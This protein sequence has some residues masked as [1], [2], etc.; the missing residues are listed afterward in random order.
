MPL[1]TWLRNL[2][3]RTKF[4]LQLA[5]QV[6][7]LLLMGAM[8]FWAL[9][10]FEAELAKASGHALEGATAQ[11]MLNLK[12]AMGIFVLIALTLGTWISRTVGNHITRTAKAIDE[13]MQSLVEG[14]LT[15]PPQIEAK[16]ELGHIAKGLSGVIQKLRQDLQAIAGISVRTA[17]GAT[18]LAATTDLLNQSTREIS[19]S[20]DS[21][22]DAMQQSSI[23]LS[24]VGRSVGEVRSQAHE[25]G[26][27]SEQALSISAQGLAEAEESLRA[28]G[29]IEESSAKV[30][31]ITT[32]IADIARQ[33]NLL[34]L[35]AAIEAAKAGTQ[36]KGFAVVAEEIRK[37]AERSG[38]A[39]KEISAL[40][41]ESTDRVAAGSSAVG[42]VSRALADLEASIRNNA[43]RIAAII[44]STEAQARATEEVAEAVGTTAQLTERSAS[45][46]TEL[47][48]SLEPN[49]IT[50]A[51][52]SR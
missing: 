40:I 31:R 26:G 27:A 15:N 7:P 30:G 43:E 10:Q 11:L 25:A 44:H 36:G 19:Q 18:E 42:S 29:A 28:M 33:T 24:D 20:V 23:A 52:K 14:D 5:V 17:S 41:Q 12:V 2:P 48:S 34:S 37:L 9:G 50:Q 6:T 1:S 8:G 39:A 46:T 16:D 13:S 3:F 51:P 35:N 32:V 38:Q 21:Q 4:R 22:R 47:A 45:A 49:L